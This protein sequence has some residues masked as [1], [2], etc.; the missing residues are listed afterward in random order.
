M[1][2]PDTDVPTQVRRHRAA[3]IVIASAVVFGAGLFVLNVGAFVRA[4]SAP[5]EIMRPEDRRL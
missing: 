2:A 1:S 5:E 4:G 3:L